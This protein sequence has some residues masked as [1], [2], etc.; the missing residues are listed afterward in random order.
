MSGELLVQCGD[1][2]MRFAYEELKIDGEYNQELFREWKRRGCQLHCTCNPKGLVEMRL[3]KHPIYPDAYVLFKL[4]EPEFDHAPD[5]F[6]FA[7][8]CEQPVRRVVHVPGIEQI[9]QEDGA[10]IWKVNVD[11]FSDEDDGEEAQETQP[12]HVLPPEHESKV[13]ALQKQNSGSGTAHR[14]DKITFGGFIR[15]WYEVGLKNATEYYH[16][17]PKTVKGLLQ[18]MRVVMLKDRL[19]LDDGR[20]LKNLA[21]IPYAG[22][23]SHIPYRQVVVGFAAKRERFE[24]DDSQVWQI[25]G[26][27]AACSIRVL[28]RHLPTRAWEGHLCALRVQ[29]EPEGMVTTHKVFE[30]YLHP[31]RCAW[32]DSSYEY[33]TYDKMV[34]MGLQPE[35]P[36]EPMEEFE[37][38]KPD[39]VV[40][41]SGSPIVIE[42]WGMAES[43]AEYRRHMEDKRGVYRAMERAGV[44]RLLEWNVERDRESGLTELI[45]RLRNLTRPARS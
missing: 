4:P 34:R 30:T 45:N 8:E 6:R 14:K 13:R 26:V 27:N 31:Y 19:R 41:G 38:Y 7:Q 3:R 39:F 23:K 10:P 32:L 15:F 20:P 22:P 36:L 37:G 11:L 5:C 2:E 18:N 29:N 42:V 1:V 12:K 9:A 40:R 17:P 25:V 28:R 44:L 35:K 21:L 24:K 33:T 16:E 43:N